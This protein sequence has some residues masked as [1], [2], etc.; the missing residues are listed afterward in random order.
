MFRAERHGG[1]Y[2]KA[3]DAACEEQNK[4]KEKR[5]ASDQ[6]LEET[7]PGKWPSLFAVDVASDGSA[8]I[9]QGSGSRGRDGSQFQRH[10]LGG[11]SRRRRREREGMAILG[12]AVRGV[13]VNTG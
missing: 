1:D 6:V 2:K 12:D 3:A 10:H 11:M 9:A 8:D 13:S 7:R 4:K 5:R